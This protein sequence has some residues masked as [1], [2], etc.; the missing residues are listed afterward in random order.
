ME[1]FDA[2]NK[3]TCLIE[4]ALKGEIA[5]LILDSLIDGLTPNLE[6]SRQVIKVML[7]EFE[8]HQT[9]CQMKKSN[10]YIATNNTEQ[11]YNTEVEIIEPECQL[12]SENKLSQEQDDENM[13][14]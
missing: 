5:W 14:S 9:M 11:Q 4:M 8:S 1:K 2:S 13:I 12:E 3:I 10:D 6:S 7:K